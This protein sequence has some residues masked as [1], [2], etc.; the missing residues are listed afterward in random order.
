MQVFHTAGVPPSTGNNIFATIGST[1]KSKAALTKIVTAK[2]AVSELSL[3]FILDRYPEPIEVHFQLAC[4]LV[5]VP[6]DFR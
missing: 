4:Y 2:R 5:D 3:E 6:E 1:E